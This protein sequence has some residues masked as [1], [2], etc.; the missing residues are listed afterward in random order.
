MPDSTQETQE[1]IERVRNLLAAVQAGLWKRSLEHDAS[2]LQEPEKSGFDSMT[3]KLKDTEYGSEE[4]RATLRE[5]KP[6][7]DHHYANNRHHPEHWPGGIFDMSLLDLVEMLC[8]WK[9]ASERMK[10]GGSVGRSIVLNK[11]RFKIDN[12]L[13]SI[14]WNTALELKWIDD[15][16]WEKIPEWSNP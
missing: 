12:Q 3:Q 10:D 14:L 8:D 16:E 7:I 1:H 5:F 9:A 4:Y 6:V 13:E 11:R 2:K 15:K